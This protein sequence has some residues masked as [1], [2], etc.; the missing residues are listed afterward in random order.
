MLGLTVV[1]AKSAAVTLT[2]WVP[3][4]VLVFGEPS[5]WRAFQPHLLSYDSRAVPWTQSWAVAQWFTELCYI[6]SSCWC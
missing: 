2:V 6:G 1:L 3:D 5:V 4:A